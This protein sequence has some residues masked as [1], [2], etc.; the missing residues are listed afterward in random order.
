MIAKT[1]LKKL[2]SLGYSIIPVDDK[3][4]PI[5]AWKSY[6]QQGRNPDQVEQLDAPLY[7]LVTGV[8]D[9]ECIDVDLK[10]IVGLQEQ[11]DW[12][13]DYLAFLNDNIEDFMTKVVI[14]KTKNAGYHILYRCF[15]VAGNTKIATLQGQKEA[16][17]ESRGGG[18]M[19]VIYENYITKR[20]YHELSY[21]TPEER[22]ILWSISRTYHYTGDMPT[23]EPKSGSNQSEG[24]SPWKD[25][26][27]KHT[28][29][30]VVSDEFDIVR[31]T[32]S[33]YIIRRH[34]ASSPHSGYVY[35]DS[36]C[37]YLFSTGTSYPAE[38]L[39]SPF[40]C[41]AYKNHLGDMQAAANDL[42]E[43]G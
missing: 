10:V 14:V 32:S 25:Y 33:S 29:L 41:Y 16:I 3:K 42:Y 19:V 38:E 24:I 6:Q 26:N 36:G 11:K 18:G 23:E 43:R 27:D 2:A 9:V 35:K 8:N 39:L 37:M 17:I 20:R 40:A 31:N 28:A 12:W 7:G 34:M 22:E 21:I 4:R 5:G 1:Y 30:D 13:N 15:D